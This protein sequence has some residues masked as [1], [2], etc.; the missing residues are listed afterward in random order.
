M[1]VKYQ[2]RHANLPKNAMD[3]SPEQHWDVFLLDLSIQHDLARASHFNTN[4]IAPKLTNTPARVQ[5]DRLKTLKT[6]LRHFDMK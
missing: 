1:A 3:Y 2:F 4:T 5:F 6:G